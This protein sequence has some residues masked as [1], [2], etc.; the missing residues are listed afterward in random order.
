[1][2]NDTNQEEWRNPLAEWVTGIVQPTKSQTSQKRSSQSSRKEDSEPRRFEL[3]ALPK[4]DFSSEKTDK[5]NFDSQ[6]IVNVQT[7]RNGIICCADGSYVKILEIMPLNYYQKDSTEKNKITESFL[8]LFRTCPNTIRIK[9]RTEKSDTYAIVNTIRENYRKENNPML[10]QRAEEYIAHILG[11]Q[12]ANTVDKR[13]Y[14]IYQYEGENGKFSRNFNDILR[15]MRSIEHDIRSKMISAGNLVVT[16]ENPDYHA[17]EVL[18][19]FYNPISCAEEPLQTRI[20]RIYKDFQKTPGAIGKPKEADFIAPRGLSSK[21]TRDW[22]LMDG[23]YHTWLVIRDNAYPPIVQTGWLD[24]IPV[25]LGV[26]IDIF[27]KRCNRST[28]ESGLKQMRKYK[29]SSYNANRSNMDKAETL[30]KEIQNAEYIKSVMSNFDEDLFNVA[31]I[32]TVRGETF[33]EMR[34]IKEAIQKHLEGL[35]IYTSTSFLSAHEFLK[36]VAPDMY[37]NKA[38]FKKYSHNFL[39]RNMAQLYPFTSMSLFDNEGYVVGRNVLGSSLVSFNNFNTQLYSN[40]NIIIMGTPGSGKSFL[41]MM[42]GYRMR[43]MGVRTMYILPLKAHEYYN[44]C[45]QIGG[46][47]IKFIP[48]GKTCVNIMEIRPQVNAS[49]ELLE[50]SEEVD[51]MDAPL[52]A[53][54]IA[55]LCAWLQLNMLDDHLTVAEKNRFNVLC[56]KLYANYGITSNNDSIWQDKKNRIL[57]TMPILQDLN[58]ALREDPILSRVKDVL[59]PYMHG[60]MFSNFNGPTNVNLNNQFLVFDVDKT[61]INEDYLPALMYIA[62][63][64]CYD[65]AKQSLMHKDA[66]FMDEVWLM[67]Q[68]DDCAKQVKEMVKIIRGYGA[69]TVLATQDIGDFLRSNDGL[70]ESILAASKIKFF[71][72]IEDMELNNVA[73]VVDLNAN[74]RANFKKFPP[75]GRALLMSDKD[76]IL[77][78][79][80]SSDQELKTFTTDVNLR[81]KF[82]TK[83]KGI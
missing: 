39:T 33:A 53:R 79:M 31:I 76:K 18:Y 64:C 14:I 6:G 67:M 55:S 60:G 81:K 15:T 40:G 38:Y 41:E 35:S 34:A 44:A 70:G 19:K 42:L 59:S 51:G 43:M 32:I 28:V 49:G 26:D 25:D 20:D 63:D 47:Y 69:C 74:D 72:R 52:L 4:R 82:A 30:S 37:M 16:P 45:E 10:A 12:N 36:C 46:E 13:F 77:I 80:I 27:A 48:G 57:K 7:I 61:S 66:I 50:D 78:D 62:F 11:L 21:T 17:C 58:D 71:L 75:H 83:N 68:N 54:K 73:R 5:K 29:Y 24:N 22:L 2:K 65:L 9:M 56:T 23:M 8:Q 1:M 3:P